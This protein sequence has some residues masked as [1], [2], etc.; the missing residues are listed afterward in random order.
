MKK[1]PQELCLIISRKVTTSVMK[2]D[3]LLSLMEQELIARELTAT[4]APQPQPRQIS[5]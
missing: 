4:N 5:N 3:E 1:L 2:L